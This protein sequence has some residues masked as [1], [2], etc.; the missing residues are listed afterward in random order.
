MA[1][2]LASACALLLAVL[3]PASASASETPPTITEPTA[4]QTVPSPVSVSGTAELIDSV[5]LDVWEGN[6]ASGSPAGGQSV[7]NVGSWSTQLTLPPG[8]YTIVAVA[9]GTEET[10]SEPVTFTVPAPETAPEVTSNPSNRTVTEGES[11]S[12]SA[13]A[14][15]NPTPTAEWE[16]STDGGSSWKDTGSGGDTFQ[17]ASTTTSENGW[18]FRAMFTNSA[19]KEHSASAELLVNELQIPPEVTAN[20]QGQTV[21]AGESASFFASASGTPAPS[22][23]W[24]V[25]TNGGSNWSSAGGSSDTFETGPTNTSESGRLYRAVFHNSAGKAT[26]AAAELRVEAVQFAPMLESSPSNRTVKAG[27]SASFSASAS[28]NPTPSIEWQV[29]TN[30]GGSWSAAGGSGNTFNT[31]PTNT[32]EN[33]YEY[34]AVFSN[35]KGSTT[36]GVATLEVLQGPEITGSPAN[37]KVEAG[38]PASFT[39]SAA[40]SPAPSV[41]W[42]VSGDGGGSWASISGANSTTFTIA[43]TTPGENNN[44]YR[45][46][47]HNASGNATSAPARL[48]VLYAPSLTG[49]PSSRV[50]TEPESVSFSATAVGNPGPG[51]QWQVSEDEG[52]TWANDT[53]PS[54]T[55]PTLKIAATN[56]EQSGNQYRAVFTNGVGSPAVSGVAVLTVHERK[57][58]P[59]VTEQ[60]ENQ[61]VKEGETAVFRSAATGVPFP[62]IQW[63]VSTNG[64]VSWGPDSDPDAK[65]TTLVLASVPASHNNYRYRAT[66]SNGVG[67]PVHSN[68]AKL[69]VSEKTEAP[70][71]EASPAN[72]EV[73]EGLPASFTAK[74]G[75]IPTPT[76]QWEVSS[77]HGANWAPVSGATFPKLTIAAV[78]PAENE[79]EYRAVFT[80]KIGLPA[81]SGIAKLTVLSPPK[82]TLGPTVAVAEHEEAVF[83]AT[84]TGVPAPT[85]QWEYAPPGSGS[86]KTA[87]SGPE[88]TIPNVTEALNGYQIKAVAKNGVGTPAEAVAILEVTN[89]PTVKVNPGNVV[90]NA[91]SPAQFTASASG[92]PVPNQV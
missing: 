76:V 59:T 33:G 41:Q 75:G 23:E 3:A 39:A 24:Q 36:S 9:N 10:R 14:T 26:S 32:G 79:N 91:G 8:T 85:I 4:F 50:V 64:G 37:V 73:Q 11:A 69:T 5:T 22:V 78:K 7:L 28:G 70:H 35:S 61:I 17:I 71:I 84:A 80:N 1:V 63:E 45:A 87:G 15:G 25:S 34:R 31:G 83:T 51:V 72:V 52:K 40:G 86:F 44:Q 90:A 21:T 27:E 38:Q 74:A 19:G 48:E 77:N 53:E 60:P 49:N 82:L 56:V 46:V 55:S 58:G 18:K 62:S 88:F 16:Y 67:A 68:E 30:G 13:S 54:A 65:S 2:A 20:P 89:S 47:F 6:S 66:F 92:S 12:F 43:S 29:S 42:Q 81:T 57:V